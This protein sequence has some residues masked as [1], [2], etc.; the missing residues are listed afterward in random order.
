MRR[1][2]PIFLLAACA[3]SGQSAPPPSAPEPI[4]PA[5]PAA[6][7]SGEVLSAWVQLG[8]DGAAQAR[9]VTRFSVCPQ[10]AIGTSNVANMSARA[11]AGGGFPLVCSAPLPAGA[12]NAALI[13]RAKQ[14]RIALPPVASEPKRIL[15]LGD[16][17]CRVKGDATQACNDPARWPFPAVAAAAAR[18]KPDLIVDVGDYLYRESACPKGDAGCAGTPFG[19]NWPTWNADFFA[20]AAPLLAAAPWVFV[21]GNHEDCARAGAGW[22]RLLGPLSFDASA[23][24]PAHL[25]PYSVPAGAMSLVV[26]DDANAPDTSVYAAMTGV[27][28]AEFAALA[29]EKEPVWLVMHRPVWGAIKGPLGIPIGGNAT[30][31]EAVGEAGIAKPVTLMLSGHIHAFEAINYEAKAPPLLVAG[32]GGD[33]LDETPQDL[34]GAIFQ[35]HSG[36]A[37]KDGVSIDGFGFV[38]LSKSADGWN[39]D[40]YDS[41][42]IVERRCAFERRRIDCP[43]T[44]R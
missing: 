7:Q 31:I 1:L 32:V 25:A 10:I 44:A 13:D 20:P 5:A 9:A 24:C 28:R 39:V 17:G 26:M 34:G 2:A 3:C 42:G 37:V 41:K 30:L 36:V 38:L 16:T 8:P 15:I 22:I 40:L 12:Q 14:E 4:A 27:Y 43:Q 23:L 19:D 35:G 33:K 21:R 6:L 29:T 11:A 18:L